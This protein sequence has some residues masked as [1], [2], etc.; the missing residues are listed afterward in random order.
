M[1]QY[2]QPKPPECHSI[3]LLVANDDT[4]MSQSKRII[5][6]LKQRLKSRGLSYA[7]VAE[8]LE[9]SESSVKRLFSSGGFSLSRLEAVSELAGVDLLELVRIADEQRLR[10]PSLS[11]EQEEEIVGDPALLLV[12]VCVLNRWPFE[13][14]LGDYRFTEP[15]LIGLL[16]RLDRMGVIELLPGNR[17]RLLITRNFAWLPDGPIHRYFVKHVQGD[18]LAGTFAADRDLHRFAWG[19]LSAESASA[20]RARL[21]ELLDEFDDLSRGDEV[22]ADAAATGTCLLIALREWEP[23]AFHAMRRQEPS[24]GEAS[25]TADA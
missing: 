22:R 18:L 19:M 15:G 3:D 20:L 23:A 5:D 4:S 25:P 24:A 2:L 6:A 16:A 1:G 13:R 8:R 17:I 12:A 10:V 9:L 21:A 7:H 14:I 11:V